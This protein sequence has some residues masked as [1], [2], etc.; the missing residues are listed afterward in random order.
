MTIF[1]ATSVA[2][3]LTTS[4]C[5]TE[6]FVSI[7]CEAGEALVGAF[8]SGFGATGATT[9][10]CGAGLG[11]VDVLGAAA[12]AATTGGF[13]AIAGVIDAGAVLAEAEGAVALCEVGGSAFFTDSAAA[14][15]AVGADV[16]V[17]SAGFFLKKLDCALTVP[18]AIENNE[19]TTAICLIFILFLSLCF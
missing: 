14:G 12:G 15:A 8:T 13:V 18:C 7:F 2:G 10:A 19:I 16:S 9:G 6:S 5:F 17:V 11:A 4:A 3:D 1:V